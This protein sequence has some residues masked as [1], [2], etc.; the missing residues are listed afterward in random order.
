MILIDLNYNGWKA[1]AVD[2]NGNKNPNKWG[3]DIFTFQAV[4][5]VHGMTQYTVDGYAMSL[6]EKGGRTPL[7]MLQESLK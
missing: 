1:F 6:T 5:D 2:I 3:Y 7:Q 4:G